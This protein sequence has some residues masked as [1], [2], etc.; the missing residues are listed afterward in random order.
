MAITRAQ[1]VRQMLKDGEVA[2]Q[3]GVKNYLGKQK[4]VS[5]VPLKWQEFIIQN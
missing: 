3:G 4:T 1:Q 5:N 2:M